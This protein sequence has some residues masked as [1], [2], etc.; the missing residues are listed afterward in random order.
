[1][2]KSN[3]QTAKLLKEPKGNADEVRTNMKI[4]PPTDLY[5]SYMNFESFYLSLFIGTIEEFSFVFQPHIRV[6]T[7]CENAVNT[8][9]RRNPSVCV[10]G[11]IKY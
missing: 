4:L 11:N 1:M 6:N 7:L 10:A 9:Y 5:E 8:K 2:K 3:I